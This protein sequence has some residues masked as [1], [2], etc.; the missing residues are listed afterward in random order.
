MMDALQVPT[1]AASSNISGGDDDDVR[2]L[3]LDSFSSSSPK[4]VVLEV[5]AAVG[6]WRKMA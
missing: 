4:G 3:F 2:D 5:A 6:T 1:Q